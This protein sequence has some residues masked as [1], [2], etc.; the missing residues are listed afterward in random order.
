VLQPATRGGVIAG[1]R[2]VNCHARAGIKA[3]QRA[4]RWMNSCPEEGEAVGLGDDEVRGEQRNVT[5]ERFAEEAIGLDVVLV[6][7]A[8]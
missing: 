5:R 2:E 8:A 7:P 3:L 4:E 1:G 6:A